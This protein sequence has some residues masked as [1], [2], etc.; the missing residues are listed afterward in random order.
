MKSL[1]VLASIGAL[2]FG[3]WYEHRPITYPP[4]VLISSD[5]EQTLEADATPIAYH[6]FQLKPLAHFT[7]DARVLHRKIYRYDRQSS[8]APVDLALGWGPMSNQGVLDRL[9]ISQS[10]RFYW[11]EYQLPPPIA[12]EEIVSHS[13]NVHVIPATEEVARHCKALRVGALIHLR[14]E[15]VEATGPELGTGAWGSSL[16]RTDTGNGACELMWVEEVTELPVDQNASQPIM[17]RR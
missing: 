11:Y 16:S 2:T 12:P 5:P 10:M 14:G 6:T 1:C 7:V 17:A 9:T 8:L 4:G 13:T 15:L 3:Y